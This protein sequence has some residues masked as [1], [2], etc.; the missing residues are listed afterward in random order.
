MKLSNDILFIALRNAIKLKN[1]LRARMVA[2]E[3]LGR[4]CL[5]E[6]LRTLPVWQCEYSLVT[7]HVKKIVEL[8][9]LDEKQG[10]DGIEPWVPENNT[11]ILDYVG[12]IAALP[13]DLDVFTALV[14]VKYDRMLV[15]EPTVPESMRWLGA[16]QLRAMYGGT[17]WDGTV[18]KVTLDVWGKR[19]REHV[20][21]IIDWISKTE[22]QNTAYAVG[23]QSEKINVHPEDI[24]WA[25]ENHRIPFTLLRKLPKNLTENDF[26]RMWW[27]YRI[28]AYEGVWFFMGTFITDGSCS[29]ES[30]MS[31]C[32]AF[33]DTLSIN[34]QW[35][36]WA[37]PKIDQMVEKELVALR[38]YAPHIRGT[39]T[40]WE[41]QSQNNHD[42]F[43]QV[44]YLNG[45]YTCSCDYFTHR[46]KRCK[47]IDYIVEHVANESKKQ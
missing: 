22:K 2:K 7:P 46:H 19:P 17:K 37:K 9:E 26:K 5:K 30:V 4:G 31:S 36:S 24:E 44:E 3:L 35:K 16:L 43:Y 14:D 32:R 29:W 6:L 23:E 15:P 38:D 1:P 18:M 28:E 42:K 47:H 25:Y 27:W 11:V 33:P 41:I 13:R 21:T 39:I 40:G 10:Q 20:K 12:L 45:A 34:E 8:M